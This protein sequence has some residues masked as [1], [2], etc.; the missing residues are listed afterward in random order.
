VCKVFFWEWD[1]RWRR[2]SAFI[3]LMAAAAFGRARTTHLSD[4]GF[5][6]LTLANP[7]TPMWPL[8][9]AKLDETERMKPDR[10]M[11]VLKRLERC[12]SQG[13]KHVG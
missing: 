6:K 13:I 7:I 10:D 12:H 4:D 8:S 5:A 1:Q 11:L 9:T 3:A 2:Y